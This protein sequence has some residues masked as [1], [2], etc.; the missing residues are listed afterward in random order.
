MKVYPYEVRIIRESSIGCMPC[1]TLADAKL[2]INQYGNG[3]EYKIYNNGKL[4]EWKGYKQDSNTGL[5]MRH[6]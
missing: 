3:K 6:G 4:I 2:H 5:W 1:R